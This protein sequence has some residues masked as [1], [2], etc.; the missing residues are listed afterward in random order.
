MFVHVEPDDEPLDVLDRLHVRVLEQDLVLQKLL[1]HRADAPVVRL[2]PLATPDDLRCDLERRAQKGRQLLIPPHRPHVA[3]VND[4][5]V[6][7]SV[8]HQVGRLD[9]PVNQPVLVE[10][11]E[12]LEAL[13]DDEA[14][15]VLVHDQAQVAGLHVFVEECLQV[16]AV[17]LLDDLLEVGVV[18]ELF[19]VVDV[20]VTAPQVFEALGFVLDVG[21]VVAL[22]DFGLDQPLDRVLVLVDFVQAE[23]H[24]A[25]GAG[26]DHLHHFEVL[27]AERFH[28]CRQ[29]L[30]GVFVGFLGFLGADDE[31]H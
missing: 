2:E 22:L 12:G 3:L 7:L 8:Q 31:D 5:E 19:V 25:V 20:G 28:V 15:H 24:F 21:F 30:L 23:E 27:D 13:A 16:V 26:A 11:P 17:D 4:L 1:S 14:C 6:A 10:E 29:F 9:V 18:L